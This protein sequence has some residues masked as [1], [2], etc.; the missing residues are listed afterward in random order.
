MTREEF[1]KFHVPA[2]EKNEAR[3]GLM[4]GLLTKLSD[5]PDTP[6]RL[7][8]FG[9][10]GACA[11]QTDPARSIV[12]GNLSEA[13]CHALAEQVVAL[14]F[15][16]AQGPDETAHWFVARARQLGLS[17]AEPMPLGIQ[18]LREAPIYPNVKGTA[19][20]VIMDDYD[21]F[22]TWYLAFR[23]EAIPSDPVPTDDHMRKRIAEHKALF[24]E[25]DGRPVSLASVSRGTR[26]G[27]G[28]GPVYTPPEHRNRGYAGAVT[29]AA[30]DLIFAS[31]KSMVFLFT[32]LRNPYSNRCYEKIGFRQI[33]SS[34]QY[35]RQ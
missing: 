27:G 19:R 16:G 4:L 25:V 33:C 6:M 15:G 18:E 5:A 8:T 9:K 21:L 13:E 34:W 1:I 7:W 26:N 22:A 35:P 23:D 3:H 17:F 2:L 10:P 32:D 14:D 20:P 31:G 11:L 30:A 29:A 24:W 28:I 12:L